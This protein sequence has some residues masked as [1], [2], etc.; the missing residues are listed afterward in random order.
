[1]NLKSTILKE[2]KYL[3][4]TKCMDFYY[5]MSQAM[6]FRDAGLNGKSIIKSEGLFTMKNQDNSFKEV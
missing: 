4:N 2:A 1:M 5:I 6:L 3:K